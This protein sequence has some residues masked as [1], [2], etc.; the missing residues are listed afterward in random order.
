MIREH[1]PAVL[2]RI[3]PRSHLPSAAQRLVD[4][5]RLPNGRLDLGGVN[6]TVDAAC[7]SSL[8]AVALAVQALRAR[9]ADAV[10]AGGSPSEPQT[11]SL[12]CNIKWKEGNEPQYF[13]PQG[14]A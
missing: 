8:F 1:G 11:P 9:R 3:L 5:D 13:N 12:G 7:A 14:T 4:V 6:Y 10:L 2:H